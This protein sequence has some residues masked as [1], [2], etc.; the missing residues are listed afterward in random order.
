MKELTG[1]GEANTQEVGDERDV[2]TEKR[3]DD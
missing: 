1:E 2:P 3:K